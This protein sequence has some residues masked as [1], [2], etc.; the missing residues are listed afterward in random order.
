MVFIDYILYASDGQVLAFFDDETVATA[1]PG[2]LIRS[3]QVTR[4]GE[5][6]E[7]ID[8]VGVTTETVVREA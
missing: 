2:R 6:G 3:E 7:Y 1:G 8:F 4:D 5:P